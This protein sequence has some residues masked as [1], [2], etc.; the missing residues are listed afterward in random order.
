MRKSE[1]FNT[2]RNHWPFADGGPNGSNRSEAD[3]QHGAEIKQTARKL[4]VPVCTAAR[5]ANFRDL[6]YSAR[7]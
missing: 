2:I 1:F 3:D 7:S 5:K 6:F 4:D